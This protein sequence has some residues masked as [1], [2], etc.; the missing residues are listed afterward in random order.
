M[1]SLGFH[2]LVLNTKTFED[3]EDSLESIAHE[4]ERRG[5]GK[6]LWQETLTRLDRVSKQVPSGWRGGRI[7]LELHDGRAAASEE[8][9]LGQ[10]LDRIGLVSAVPA[11]MGAFPKLSTEWV[12]M[13][14][15][16]KN[17]YMTGEQIIVSGGYIYA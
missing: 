17:T 12:L 10:L 5:A 4:L 7:Y 14:A 3:V 11:G 8:S 2:V 1:R 15:G 16:P 9:F 13:A 6:T